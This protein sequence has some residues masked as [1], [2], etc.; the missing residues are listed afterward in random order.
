[1][2]V[3][4]PCL[5]IW[6]ILQVYF[7]WK[8]FIFSCRKVFIFLSTKKYFHFI[9]SEI[10]LKFII[11]YDGSNNH[12]LY[13]WMISYLLFFHHFY[14]RLLKNQPLWSNL[15]I[16]THIKYLFIYTG[17]LIFYFTRYLWSSIKIFTKNC[18]VLIQKRQIFFNRV[19]YSSM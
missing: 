10:N 4:C 12:I 16:C 19:R 13:I 11:L 3:S 6:S 18:I 5:E 7:L 14:Y 17:K 8:I 2:V 15:Y 1:M 9:W